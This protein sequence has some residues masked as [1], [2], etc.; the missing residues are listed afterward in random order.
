MSEMQIQ[1][2]QDI[3]KMTPRLSLDSLLSVKELME[4]ALN[5][6]LIK[7]EPTILLENMDITE[8]VMYLDYLM[9]GKE[10]KEEE[11]KYAVSLEDILKR[12]GL[13]VDDLQN[14]H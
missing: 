9:E 3:I 5:T 6:E 13:T 14:Y 10:T 2:M 12:E 4:Q 11:L 7:R 1:L 8:K